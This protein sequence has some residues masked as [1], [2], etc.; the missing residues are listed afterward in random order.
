MTISALIMFVAALFSALL[1]VWMP[2]FWL[3]AL[4]FLIDALYEVSRAPRHAE[5]HLKHTIADY[6]PDYIDLGPDYRDYTLYYIDLG[7]DDRDY[8]PADY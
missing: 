4:K 7:L 1:T 2:W 8:T 5:E 3:V 6:T